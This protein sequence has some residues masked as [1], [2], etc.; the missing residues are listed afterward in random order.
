MTQEQKAKKL[1]GKRLRSPPMR[2]MS[3]WLPLKL[4]SVTLPQLVFWQLS[5]GCRF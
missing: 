4:Q 2:H 3:K 5:S 1:L